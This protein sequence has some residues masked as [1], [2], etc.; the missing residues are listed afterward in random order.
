[1]ASVSQSRFRSAIRE[2]FSFELYKRTQGRRVRQLSALGIIVFLG[3]GVIALANQLAD[4]PPWIQYG[5]PAAVGAAAL[6]GTFRLIHWPPFADFLIATEA[7]MGKVSW[8]KRDELKRATVVVM[9]TLFLLAGFLF[10]VDIAWSWFLHRVGVLEIAPATTQALLD[11]H[12]HPVAWHG[13]LAFL[14]R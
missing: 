11:P 3:W 2:L 14:A 10:L 9:L 12:S 8:P 13:L 5:V 4:Q 1:M 6:W 7:E